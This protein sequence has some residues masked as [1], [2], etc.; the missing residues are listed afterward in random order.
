M[1]PGRVAPASVVVGKGVVGR[2]V[3][4]GG[5]RDGA[6]KAPLRIVHAF[7]FVAGAAA[8]AVVEKG[9]AQSRCVGAVTLAVQISVATSSPCIKTK[10]K[11]KK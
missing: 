8:E 2:A 10:T 11:T 9:G 5:H 3:V 6:R 1:L 4:G 7:E